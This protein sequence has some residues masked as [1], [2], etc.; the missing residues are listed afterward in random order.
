MQD[1]V[2]DPERRGDQVVPG[3]VLRQGGHGVLEERRVPRRQ[4]RRPVHAVVEPEHAFLVLAPTLGEQRRV[5]VEL[6]P[7]LGAGRRRDLEGAGQPP[8][9][10]RHRALPRGQG[11]RDA[12]VAGRA[13]RAH[14]R[15]RAPAPHRLGAALQ[16]EQPVP[17]GRVGLDRP[18]DV[19]R[20]AVMPLGPPG[21][22][23]H[24]LD[25]LVG[26]A[27]HGAP[28]GG[29]RDPD[30]PAAVARRPVLDVLVGDDPPGDLHAAPC[31]PG[32]CPG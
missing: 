5:G 2:V 22:L 27:R 21:E 31:R 7:A 20:A 6:L 18:L 14:R 29:H 4:R 16:Q 24:L 17:A 28:L 26:Q 3:V 10:A 12:R 19:L 23:G 11:R 1:A 9:P 25:L 13:R 32:S 30:D 8:T 15:R